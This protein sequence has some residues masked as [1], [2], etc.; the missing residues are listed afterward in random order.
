MAYLIRMDKV[1]EL[2]NYGRRS[3]SSGDGGKVLGYVIN[4]FDFEEH[5]YIIKIPKS[6]IWDEQLKNHL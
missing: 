4:R 5:F 2:L 1:N 3:E 6:K